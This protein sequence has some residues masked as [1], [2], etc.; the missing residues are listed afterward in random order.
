[1]GRSWKGGR[2]WKRLYWSINTTNMA[3]RPPT[4]SWPR[5]TKPFLRRFL[6]NWRRIAT[7][8]SKT[9][10]SWCTVQPSFTK[11]F[12]RS[13][14]WLRHIRSIWM[15]GMPLKGLLSILLWLRVNTRTLNCCWRTALM[16]TCKTRGGW[17]HC[18]RLFFGG[19]R[20]CV[21]QSSW[22]ATNSTKKLSRNYCSMGQIALPKPK[23]DTLH[24]TSC[25]STRKLRKTVSM[26][27]RTWKW[28]TGNCREFW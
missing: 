4:K 26:M 12:C 10:I 13:F 14:S 21:S 20:R 22:K 23:K 16:S 1:M 7:S 27:M 24:K 15:W 25:K 11:V 3:W 5:D 19:V 8:N 9:E 6:W 18:T 28:R 17:L 2:F